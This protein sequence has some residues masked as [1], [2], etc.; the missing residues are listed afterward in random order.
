MSSSQASGGEVSVTG[1][2][3]KVGV[4]VD[5]TVAVEGLVAD[6]YALSMSEDPEASDVCVCVYVCM[7]GV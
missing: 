4:L 3:W 7:C 2:V 6:V 1:G 5:V